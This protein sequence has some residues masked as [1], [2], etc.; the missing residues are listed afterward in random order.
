MR[1]ALVALVA[2]VT[3]C[4]GT[5]VPSPEPCVPDWTQDSAPPVGWVAAPQREETPE[6]SSS[7]ADGIGSWRCLC[8]SPLVVGD[9]WPLCSLD[10]WDGA[11]WQEVVLRQCAEGCSRTGE[12]LK[13]WAG[14]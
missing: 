14:Q 2:L 3:A 8:F 4:G 7:D 1:F 11:G 6:A 13:S 9:P 5:Q 12:R 10:W